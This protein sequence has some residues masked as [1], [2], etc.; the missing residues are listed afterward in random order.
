LFIFD[1]DDT[2][3]FSQSATSEQNC[4]YTLINIANNQ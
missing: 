4:I 2:L 1:R 3:Y